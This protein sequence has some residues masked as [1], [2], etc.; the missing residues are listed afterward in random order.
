MKII[1]ISIANWVD[2]LGRTERV[3]SPEGSEKRGAVDK[4]PP[5][6]QRVGQT[7]AGAGTNESVQKRNT[8]SSN[9]ICVRWAW[10]WR[11]AARRCSSTGGATENRESRGTRVLWREAPSNTRQRIENYCCHGL[12]PN[13]I[14]KYSAP[15][16]S[17]ILAFTVFQLFDG[18]VLWFFEMVVEDCWLYGM[19][20]LVSQ[21]QVRWV[22]SQ[23]IISGTSL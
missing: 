10:A 6:R 18:F 22:Y 7:G 13:W 11:R 4:S 14:M 17:S 23:T 12:L 5:D 21:A 15:S 9:P 3:G 20:L 1:T 19:S 16:C 8:F 2:Q